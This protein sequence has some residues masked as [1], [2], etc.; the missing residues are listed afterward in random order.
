MLDD[1]LTAL[2]R[3]SRGVLARVRFQSLAQS[4]C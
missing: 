4:D 2:A 1:F 3:R